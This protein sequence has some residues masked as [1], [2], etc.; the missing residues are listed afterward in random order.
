MYGKDSEFDVKRL[1]IWKHETP[2]KTPRSPPVSQI[3]TPEVPAQLDGTG[4]TLKTA[5]N[6][7]RRATE[8]SRHPAGFRVP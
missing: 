3:N 5:P 1:E 6:S 7:L 4:T 2:P 8:R